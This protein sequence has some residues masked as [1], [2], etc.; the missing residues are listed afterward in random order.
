MN[1]SIPW[2]I[3]AF[4]GVSG[5][6]GDLSELRLDSFEVSG[7]A[8]GVV[9]TLPQP[10]GTVSV[11]IDG[12]ASNVTIRRP[13][14]VAA[15]VDVRRGASNLAFDDQHFGAIG[16]ETRLRTSDYGGAVHRYD[17]SIAGGASDLTI[18]AR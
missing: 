15:G 2:K 17:I 5:L 14:G 6:T 8:D 7:G 1:A 3:E 16:G 4:G 11:R 18:E 13:A 10:S 9:L 12:G